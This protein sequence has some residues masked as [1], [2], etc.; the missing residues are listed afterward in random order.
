MASA[1]PPT[2]HSVIERLRRD[3]T[4]ER[5]AAF[6][7]VVDAYWKPI[8]KHFRA[9]WNA[10]PEDAQDLTQSFFSDAFEKAWLEKYEPGKARFRTFVRVCV[11]RFA[12]NARQASNRAK[13][14]GGARL[15]S[16]D[17]ETAEQEVRAQ[18][19][20][21][22]AD[23][24]DFFRREFVRAL[25]QRAIATAR[26]ELTRSGRAVHFQLFERYDLRPDDRVS[27]A[28]LAA[29]FHLS[30]SRVTNYLSVARRAFRSHALGT[31]RGLSASD[32]EFRR[33]ARDLFGMDVD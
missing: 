28:S 19:L 13:R 21:T 7:D 6:S 33:E 4:Q 20:Q 26:E 22:P 31:L 27:Y 18:S 14:G 5:A 30:E 23:A 11:D 29:E 1:F 3:D 24:E 2:R 25:F 10:S 16:L 9:T 17:F 8:Y 15:V 32:E 12:M